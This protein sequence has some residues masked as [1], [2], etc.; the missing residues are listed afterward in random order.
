MQVSPPSASLENGGTLQLAA[1]AL[2]AGGKQISG[3]IVA[4]SLSDAGVA[5][6]TTGCAPQR[7]RDLHVQRYLG[8][9]SERDWGNFG[10]QLRR[11]PADRQRGRSARQRAG[12]S[13]PRVHGHPPGV[14]GRAGADPGD[15]TFTASSG[16]ALVTISV[17]SDALN[18][19]VLTHDGKHMYI[20]DTLGTIAELDATT[21]AP[22][23]IIP[24]TGTLQD[25]D[26]SPDG[27][28][29]YVAVEDTEFDVVNVATGAVSAV[30]TLNAA[31]D[32][33]GTTL[34]VASETNARY[35]IR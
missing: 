27:T 31:F 17:A 23:R 14:R 6:S 1:A 33:A 16:T 22:V 5:T 2:T 20:S 15:L 25:I 13:D 26:I 9:H 18:G 11:R 7:D 8:V 12:G 30:V 29:L 21:D 10:A 34:A 3:A 28:E 35:V 19:L 4:F 32:S 24:L